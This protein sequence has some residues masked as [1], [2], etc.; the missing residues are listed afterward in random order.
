M[1]QDNI[2][3]RRFYTDTSSKGGRLPLFH[4]PLEVT[5]VAY[6]IWQKI[7]NYKY[8]MFPFCTL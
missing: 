1:D 7:K 5:T 6:L 3:P 2:G 4:E 8:I